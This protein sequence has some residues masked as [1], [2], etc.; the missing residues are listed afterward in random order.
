MDPL[1]DLVVVKNLAL[2]LRGMEG[3]E[4]VDNDHRCL[5]MYCN[6]GQRFQVT[7]TEVPA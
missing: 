4:N 7:V 3:V 2:Y 5:V 1:N 6:N